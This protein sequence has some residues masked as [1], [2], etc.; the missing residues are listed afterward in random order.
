MVTCQ[1][2][3]SRSVF[4]AIV[5]TLNNFLELQGSLHTSI[6]ILLAAKPV[7]CLR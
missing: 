6:D 1:I 5:V 4:S 7:P 2:R 3:Q